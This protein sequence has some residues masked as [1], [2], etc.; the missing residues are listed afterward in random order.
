MILENPNTK[1][2]WERKHLESALIVALEGPIHNFDYV[3]VKAIAL[4]RHSTKWRYLYSHHEDYLVG[5]TC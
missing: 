5:H 1:I 2:I 3:M 4:W